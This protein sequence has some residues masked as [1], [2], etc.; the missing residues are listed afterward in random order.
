MI[1]MITTTIKPA[2]AA[3]AAAWKLLCPGDDR[4]TPVVRFRLAAA[5]STLL[6][7]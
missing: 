6:Q 4:M 3:A 7:V 2:A 5:D 1:V